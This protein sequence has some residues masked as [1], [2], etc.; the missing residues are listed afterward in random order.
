MKYPYTE[1][2][3]KAALRAGSI[4]RESIGRVHVEH[5]GR[6][7]LVTDA[8]KASEQ[9]IVGMIRT[10]FPNHAI[11]AEESGETGSHEYRWYIDPLDGTT[12]YT[13]GVPIYAVSIGLAVGDAMLSGVVYLPATDELFVAEQGGGAFRNGVPIKVSQTE[14]LLDALLVTGF[15][16][17]AHE[18]ADNNLDHFGNFTVRCQGVR[19]LG[20]AAAD[21]VRVA[22]GV[23][24]GYWEVALNPWDMAAGAL[25]VQEAGG[26]VTDLHGQ[27]WTP[28]SGQLLATNGHLH[29]AMLEVLQLGK[30]G[31]AVRIGGRV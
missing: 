2:A 12:N 4:L 1:I 14:E 31:M 19:R 11:C 30:S 20:S 7:D 6:I 13:H 26:K 3:I 17:S 10:A 21:S 23:L 25:L 29:T 15:P 24:D 8:D 16:Y 27:P 28:R 5:K 9:V 18:K 22:Q